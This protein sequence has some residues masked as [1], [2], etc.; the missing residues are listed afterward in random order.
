MFFWDW[1]FN[2]KNNKYEI[3]VIVYKIQCRNYKLK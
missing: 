2:D 3:L 1:E